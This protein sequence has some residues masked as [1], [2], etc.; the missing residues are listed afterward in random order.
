M[1]LEEYLNMEDLLHYCHFILGGCTTFDTM[2]MSR[3]EVQKHISDGNLIHA[4]DQ[5]RIITN[6]GKPISVQGHIRFGR[7]N[8]RE[9][10]RD[11]DKG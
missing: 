5:V 8:Q 2:R 11:I 4:G 6:D 3:S 7:N 10:C 9:R 1:Q